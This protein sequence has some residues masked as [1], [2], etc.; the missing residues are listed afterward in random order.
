MNIARERLHTSS[1]ASK[2]L[3][4]EVCDEV[5]SRSARL[6]TAAPT[7]CSAEKVL[8]MCVPGVLPMSMLRAVRASVPLMFLPPLLSNTLAQSERASAFRE[9]FR[10]AYKMRRGL[11]HSKTSRLF[12]NGSWGVAAFRRVRA[13]GVV[14]FTRARNRPCWRA[15]GAAPAAHKLPPPP[16][17][18][19]SHAL[20]TPD[21][22]T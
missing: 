18:N 10:H 14:N 4:G 21:R 19:S 5:C 7:A 8:P 15:G 9:S 11:A 6:P 2:G 16:A 17:L 1:Q 22:L 20:Q 3:T 13:S 12:G